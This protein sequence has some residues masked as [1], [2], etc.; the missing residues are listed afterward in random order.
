MF[1]ICRKFQVSFGSHFSSSTHVHI[2]V[3]ASENWVEWVSSSQSKSLRWAEERK[4]ESG[5]GLGGLASSGWLGLLRR[6]VVVMVSV[7]LILFYKV[8]L[9]DNVLKYKIG[10]RLFPLAG[11]SSAKFVG[12][13]LKSQSCSESCNV[14]FFLQALRFVVF[15]LKSVRMVK[16]FVFFLHALRP[17]LQ[18]SSSRASS[19][20]RDVGV[21]CDSCDGSC[22]GPI[23]RP[24][25]S[26]KGFHQ[27]S[28]D[29]IPRKSKTIFVGL[30]KTKV[31]LPGKATIW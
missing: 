5:I 19:I 31:A 14:S 26:S 2:E 16:P 28:T 25:P 11:F 21:C 3:G 18:G 24:L 6:Q 1:H 13:Q 9:R 27:C 12:S 22:G 20:A 10:S 23:Q 4:V 15:Y 17:V 8:R 29:S 7:K 30:H